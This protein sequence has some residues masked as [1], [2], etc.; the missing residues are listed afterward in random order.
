ME[1]QIFEHTTRIQ[2][3]EAFIDLVT[4][5][6]GEYEGSNVSDM[7]ALIQ[8]GNGA[9]AVLTLEQVLLHEGKVLYSLSEWQGLV[10]LLGVTLD[11]GDFFNVSIHTA[12]GYAE[13]S[14]RPLSREETEIGVIH[15]YNRV[16]DWDESISIAEGLLVGEIERCALITGN[17]DRSVRFPKPQVVFSAK[18]ALI[19][20]EPELR[21]ANGGYTI[22]SSV[23]KT[24]PRKEADRIILAALQ[25][26]CG[27]CIFNTLCQPS[28]NRHLQPV[29]LGRQGGG[30]RRYPSAWS[31]FSPIKV[32]DPENGR[33]AEKFVPLPLFSN[34]GTN[35]A[36]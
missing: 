7:Q 20:S 23:E 6:G 19:G 27:R 16:V 21:G 26:V 24:I 4:A 32:K 36:P 11:D 14:Y 28:I 12:Q 9:C 29:H 13:L 5:L 35:G 17:H 8:W 33:N 3:P 15:F 31:S 25:G 18:A 34:N 22:V 2:T 30:P 1:A 10:E